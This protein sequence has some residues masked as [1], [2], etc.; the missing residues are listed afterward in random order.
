M[1]LKPFDQNTL[2]RMW[3]YEIITLFRKKSAQLII[4][5]ALKR[6]LR[7]EK[8]TFAS[9]LNNLYKK[10][11]IVHCSKPSDNHKKNVA[12]LGRYVKRPPIFW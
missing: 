6:Q 1:S 11:W 5:S 12:Y 2:M 9:L 7:K 10:L 8:L 4:P 3:R